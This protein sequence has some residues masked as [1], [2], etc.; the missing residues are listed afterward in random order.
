MFMRVLRCV[1]CGNKISDRRYNL[2]YNVCPNCGNVNKNSD[3]FI[4][5]IKSVEEIKEEPAV[6]QS[7]TDL[8]LVVMGIIVFVF[9]AAIFAAF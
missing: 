5:V 8:L 3:V 4:D 7:S 6:E 9:I 2:S 1:K